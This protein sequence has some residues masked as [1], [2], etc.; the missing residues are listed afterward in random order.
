MSGS[1]ARPR[2]KGARQV[3]KLRHQAPAMFGYLPA[4][5]GP[6]ATT[7]DLTV[8][9]GS[10]SEIFR[11]GL[12][13]DGAGRSGVADYGP[14]RGDQAKG[15]PLRHLYDAVQADIDVPS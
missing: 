2:D 9:K 4:M 3:P 11:N 8:A 5:N 14:A 13:L 12:G 10:W 15:I 1:L 7:V 6:R